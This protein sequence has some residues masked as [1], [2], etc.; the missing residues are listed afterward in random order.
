MNM[1]GSSDALLVA[2]EHGVLTL[3]NNDPPRNWM[4]FDYMDAVEQTVADAATDPAA[5]VLVFTASGDEHFS[6]G[7]DLK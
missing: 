6:V 2:L 1:R 5:R 7:M 4:T 3:T